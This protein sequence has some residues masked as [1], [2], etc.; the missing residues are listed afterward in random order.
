MAQ[1]PRTASGRVGYSVLGELAVEV[2]GLRQPIQR[3]REG[4]ILC[5]LIAARGAVVSAD[6]LVAEI[7]ADE[8]PQSALAGVSVSSREVPL[9][10]SGLSALA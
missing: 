10:T 1:P 3:R 4:L 9:G 8:S 2:D 5:L 6:R 7:W